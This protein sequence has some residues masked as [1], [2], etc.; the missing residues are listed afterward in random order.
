M[1]PPHPLITLTTDF[2]LTDEYVGTLKGVIL[3]ICPTATLVDITHDIP[4]QDIAAAARIIG[5]GYTYFPNRTIHLVIVDPGVGSSRSII[6]L[7]TPKHIFIA[8]NNGVLS[9]VLKNEKNCDAYLIENSSF[10]RHNPS[11]TFHGRDIMGPVAARIA[12]GL[13]LSKVGSAID[14][15]QCIRLPLPR[16]EISTKCIRG[17]VIHVDH[18]G[19]LQTSITGEDLVSVEYKEKIK[20]TICNHVIKGLQRNYSEV[21]KGQLV[22]LLDSSNHLEIAERNGSGAASLCCEIGEAVLITFQE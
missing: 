16:A 11:H 3:S 9:R 22:A 12:Q 5:N 17:E 19:N 20:I 2:G 6:A 7:K 15:S 8:P 10:F 4:A 13:D 18:F 1:M 21:E 14:P